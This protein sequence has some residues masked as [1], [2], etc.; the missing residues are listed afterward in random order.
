MMWRNEEDRYAS[1]LL[2]SCSHRC[3]SD[4]Q[5]RDTTVMK[6]GRA[7]EIQLMWYKNGPSVQFGDSSDPVKED[8]E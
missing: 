7:C 3:D 6:V 2:R 1:R 4:V 8:G 5:A